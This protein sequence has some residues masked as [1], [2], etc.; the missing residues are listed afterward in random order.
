MSI[1]LG[2]LLVGM[3][4]ILA[5]SPVARK[6]AFWILCAALLLLIGIWLFVQCTELWHDLPERVKELDLPI[7]VVVLGF[8]LIDYIWT[9]LRW[10]SYEKREAAR[11]AKGA[12]QIARYQQHVEEQRNKMWWT[13]K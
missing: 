13:K 7:A 3:A 1:G 2:I 12:E 11:E 8:V 5:F 9:K 4:A 10:G 6:A